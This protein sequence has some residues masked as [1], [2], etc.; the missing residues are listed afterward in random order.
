[1]KPTSLF[2][3][4]ALM[5]AGV[6]AQEEDSLSKKL[7]NPLTAMINVPTQFNYDDD[8]GVNEEGS[9]FQINIQPVIPFKIR[10]EWN[11]ITRRIV[12][13]IEQEDLAPTT[14][15]KKRRFLF[16]LGLR[17]ETG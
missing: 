6:S 10:D 4:T 8:L 5:I 7:A 13:L 9:L 2:V 12:L 11:L 1:M 17:R 16:L 14:S 3:L 15:L